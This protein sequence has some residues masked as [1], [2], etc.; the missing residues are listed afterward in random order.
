MED[1]AIGLARQLGS[2]EYTTCSRCSRPVMRREAVALASDGL[3][4]RRSVEAELCPSCRDDVARGE[5]DLREGL[6]E[7]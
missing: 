1:E 3:P 2:D 4:E 7:E 5:T 6:E